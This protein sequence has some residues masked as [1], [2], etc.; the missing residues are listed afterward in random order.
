MIT[1]DTDRF[2]K[3]QD[4]CDSYNVALEEIKRGEK[5]SHWIWYVFPQIEGLG[6]STMAKKYAIRSLQEAKAYLGN[7]K[8]NTRLREITGALLEH[9]GNKDITHIMGPIDAMKIRS[10][11][12]L[13]DIVSPYDIFEEVL[14]KFYD[15]ERCKATL[16]IV[17]EEKDINHGDK[18]EKGNGKNEERAE[19][20]A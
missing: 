10:C 5:Q 1:I 8:L 9:A 4:N 12:T 6:H 7:D 3:A 18:L 11:M 14:D 2:I 19:D 15:G 17:R 20:C 13:F 16:N